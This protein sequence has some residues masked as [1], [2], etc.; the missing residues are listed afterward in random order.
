MKDSNKYAPKVTKLFRTLKQKNSKVKQ[1]KFADPVE[2]L[3]YAVVSEQVSDSSAGRILRKMEKHFVDFNDLR[4]SRKE[5]IL[6][7]LGGSDDSYQQTAA[8]LNQVLNSIYKKY[9]MLSLSELSE[10]GKRQVRKKLEQIEGLSRFVISYCFLTVFGGHAI[11]LT[12]DMLEYLRAEELVH[13]RASDDDIEGF[14]ARQIGLKSAYE[15]YWLLRAESEKGRKKR[16]RKAE[17]A[18]DGPSAKAGAKRA[19]SSPK[20][21]VRTAKKTVKKK[22]G[23]RAS[24]GAK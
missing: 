12:D 24:K 6:D 9:D 8:A 5:E 4:V 22:T 17:E 23:K 7:V 11:P 13:P 14:L 21:K 19:K 16:S 20:R 10:V 15:F 3:V 18:E 2:G 1:P